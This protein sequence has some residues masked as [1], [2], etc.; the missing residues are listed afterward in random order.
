HTGTL[1]AVAY[2]PC[3]HRLAT[4]G[5][6]CAVILWDA[7]TGKAEQVLQGHTQRV[8]SVSFSANGARLASGSYDSS[9]RVWDTS[10]KLINSVKGCRF[11]VFSPDGRSI[12][13]ASANNFGDVELVDAAS[14]ALLLSMVGHLGHV[15]SSSFSPNGAKLASASYD[16]TCRVWDLSTGALLRT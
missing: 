7:G 11:A 10:G 5:E 14:G 1:N 12:A 3:G 15:Y 6:D 8:T 4:G 2:S 9:I 16:G 13:T